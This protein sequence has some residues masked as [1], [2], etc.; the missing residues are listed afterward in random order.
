MIVLST[1]AKFGHTPDTVGGE[2]HLLK[3]MLDK[4]RH[5][6]VATISGRA[7]KST[8]NSQ[9]HRE[10][11]LTARRVRVSHLQGP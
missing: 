10:K 2:A 7:R 6:A 4:K 3:S 1:Q 11:C 8:P 5:R 9:L